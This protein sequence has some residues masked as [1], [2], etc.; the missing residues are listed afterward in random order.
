MILLVGNKSNPIKQHIPQL[1]IQ[2]N[3]NQNQLNGIPFDTDLSSAVDFYIVGAYCIVYY[4]LQ[5]NLRKTH[6]KFG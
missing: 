3:S 2:W 5:Y 4:I 6:T 1:C